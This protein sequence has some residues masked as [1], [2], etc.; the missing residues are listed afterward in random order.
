MWDADVKVSQLP[1]TK[2]RAQ[3]SLTVLLCSGQL[4]TIIED[5]DVVVFISTL[6]GG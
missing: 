3:P 5:G 4:N 2:R 6:H 1:C